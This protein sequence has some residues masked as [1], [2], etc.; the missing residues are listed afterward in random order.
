MV[1][2]SAPYSALH[3]ALLSTESTIAAQPRIRTLLALLCSLVGLWFG[4]L[5]AR[6]AS[7]SI[8]D[9][10]VSHDSFAAHSEPAMAENPR[11]ANNLIAGSKFFTD[12]AHYQFKIGT[13]YTL[14]GGRSW[15]DAGLLPGF[16]AYSLTSDISFAFSATGVAYACVLASDGAA[17]SGIFV[18]RSTD[19]GKTWSAPATVSLDTSGA[20]FSDKPWIGIDRTKGPN[21]G[22]V[23]VAWNLDS[24]S[25]ARR[26]DP[27]AGDR[28]P[29][30]LHNQQ[31]AERQPVGLDVARSTD[32][33]QTFSSPVVVSVFDNMHFALGAIPQVAPDGV[34]Y[35]AFLSFVDTS[36]GATTNSIDLVSSQDG[37]VTFAPQR[38]SAPSID[39][40]PNH[41][42][43]GTFRNLSLPTFVVSPRDG[44]MVVAWAD[45]RSG[46]ADILAS[47]SQD[48]GQTWTA[49]YRVN[50]DHFQ[51][52]KDQFQP[53]L[54]V[55]PNGTYTC[56]WFDRR[57][58]PANQLIDVDIAQSVD[59]GLT[60]GHNVRVTHKSWDPA[61]DAPLPEGKSDNTFIGD[62]QALAVDNQTVHPLWNDTQN[63]RSQEIRSAVLSVRIFARR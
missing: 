20:T 10:Q 39:G 34:V 23:Y 61:I 50:H 11:N 17:S 62:Y 52:G 55:A 47:R 21:R 26:H 31:V 60:F 1:G 15:H 13:F 19:G 27:D 32:G 63:G 9:V 8:T 29:G 14:D 54:A 40:L 4:S 30:L 24:N 56:S 48:G 53:E 6:A 12:P 36:S 7:F 57:R 42:S 33:G 45:I 16:Q 58:D 49:P 38:T 22:T 25:D 41:L 28:A 37:G 3:D 35:V 44:S 59:G 51:N 46:D 43:A 5:P 18:S 2:C